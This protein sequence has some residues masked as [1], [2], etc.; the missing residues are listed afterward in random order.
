MYTSL[1]GVKSQKTVMITNVCGNVSEERTASIINL[2]SAAVSSHETLTFTYK[3]TRCYK[4][5]EEN[6]T[7]LQM[8]EQFI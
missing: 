4:P 8:Q 7:S 5:Q 1:H 2:K 3:K 6:I